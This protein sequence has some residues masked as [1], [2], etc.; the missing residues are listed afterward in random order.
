MDVFIPELG[1]FEPRPWHETLPLRPQVWQRA[2]L[3]IWGTK[4][5]FDFP[6]ASSIRDGR[7]RIVQ[8]IENKGRSESGNMSQIRREP[9][10]VETKA[11]SLLPPKKW[12]APF[13][14]DRL[15]LSD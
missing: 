9:S 1:W 15:A 13:E 12:T 7:G 8:A 14:V 6:Q 5:G 4:Y 3:T 11:N 10:D 2:T